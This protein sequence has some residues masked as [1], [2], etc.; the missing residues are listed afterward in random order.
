MAKNLI[1]TIVDTL[2]TDM[3]SQ[4][5]FAAVA[6]VQCPLTMDYEAF[7]LL[8]LASPISPAEEQGTD[9]ARGFALAL[10]MFKNSR[11]SQ[12][13]LVL[14]TDGEDLEKNWPES[15]KELQ[16]AKDHGFYRG[17]RHSRRSAD[18]HSG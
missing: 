14:I 5:N 15:L 1:A 13:L 9:F 2:K 6:Y 16:K 8:A 7:K 12:K 18:S 11:G 10:R 3:V 17:R 4:V